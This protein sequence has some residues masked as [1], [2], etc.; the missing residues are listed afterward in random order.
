MKPGGK[1]YV[2]EYG[3]EWWYPR[4]LQLR[5]HT[6]YSIHFGFLA[7]VAKQLNLN[8]YIA[9]LVDFLPFNKGIKVINNISWFYI[10]N[11]LLPFLNRQ[12]IP[13]MVYTE[14]MI[15]EKIGEI[16]DRLFFVGLCDVRSKEVL[17]SPVEFCVL[18]MESDKYN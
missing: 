9:S 12:K 7:K 5:G 16:F 3:S 8:P 17:M 4:A 14:N 11:L 2:V 15:K 6:E 18:S 1:A 10:N 13:K